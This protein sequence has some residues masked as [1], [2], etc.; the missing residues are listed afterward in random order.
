VANLDT[1]P[2]ITYSS[3]RTG[4]AT[5]RLSFSK[6]RIPTAVVPTRMYPLR[7]HP[8]QYRLATSTARFC[9]VPAGRRSGKTELAKRKLVKAAYA[10]TKFTDARF[11]AGAP[12]RDQAKRIFWNDL[13][14]MIPRHLMAGSP[15]ETE[16]MIPL[17]N[18]SELHVV[19]LDVPER[20]EGTPWDGGVLDEF[21]NMKAGG[22]GENIRPALSDRKGWC[23]FI[24][25]PE[26]RNHYYDLAKRAQT[27]KDPDWAYFWWPSADIL[28]PEEI[29]S[30]RR[31]LDELVFQQ[32]YEASFINFEG[33]AYYPF[34][35]ATHAADLT[36][37]PR[38]LLALCFDFNVEPGVA[39]AIQEQTLPNGNEGTGVIAQ[40]HIPRNSNTPAVCNKLLEIFA[41]HEGPVRCYGDATGGARGSAKVLGS[42]WD[43][44]KAAFRGYFPGG[45]TY[46]VKEANPPERTRINAVNSR[47]KTSDGEIHMMVDRGEAPDVVRDFEGVQLLKGGSGEI[48]K[49]ATPALTHWT[50]AIGYYVDYE[51]PIVR[52]VATGGSMF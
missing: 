3:N 28:D 40:V 45:L 34:L 37:N 9:V 22:W 15:R 33:R 19:G 31:D 24:G 14:A 42:D 49:K 41:A 25:V 51:F 8:T 38:A 43:L 44:I 11:F 32:E 26:G 16:L 5:A 7:A 46:R 21:A 48:D 18:G 29:A 17:L 23:W 39:A 20:I 47:L 10:G 36:Y 27:G 35:E 30:A 50:D 52:R 1:I 4:S 13:K 2:A 12:T 6:K